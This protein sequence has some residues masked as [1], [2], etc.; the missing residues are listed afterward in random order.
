MTGDIPKELVNPCS[1]KL[2]EALTLI[3]NVSF[4]NR[5]WPRRWKTE[6]VIPILKSIS[7]GSFDDIHPIS[8]TTLWSKILESYVATFTLEETQSNWKNN[9]YGGRKES[10]PDHVLVGLWNGILT[11]LENGA[12]SVTL[13]GIDFSKSFSRCSHQEILKAYVKLG[14]SDWGI[15]MHAAFLDKRKMRVKIGNFLSNEHIVTGGAVQG[16]V[17]GVLDHNAVLEALDYDISDQEIYKYVD[18]LTLDEAV[19]KAIPCLT[20]TDPSGVETHVFKPP[21][22]QENFNKLNNACDERGLKINNN[23]TQLLSISSGRNKTKARISLK[24]G[25]TM[26][27]NELFKLLGFIFSNTPTIHAQVDHVI[28]RATNRSF[29]LRHLAGF[30]ADK[31]K[32]K[33][34]HCSIIRSV[35]EYSSVIFGPML[36]KYEKNRL[37]NVQKNA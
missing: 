34:I 13:S 14:L 9:Q 3:Y 36:A 5:S 17:L 8:M 10:S 31:Q 18:D 2:A 26:Y 21:K 19:D 7:P 25:S 1:Y 35:M 30:G 16:S 32:L 24:D 37:E 6:T 28:N 20:E 23:K 12:K 4:L 27:S 15:Q 22:T 33:N 11:G 29:V